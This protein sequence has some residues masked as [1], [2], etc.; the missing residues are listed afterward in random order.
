[1][2]IY[3]TNSDPINEP[4]TKKQFL[5]YCTRFFK[6]CYTLSKYYK[7]KLCILYLKS[8]QFLVCF[9]LGFICIFV[10]Y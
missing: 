7:Q 5:S 4:L 10:L 1:M 2:H 8:V 9:S 6:L 3:I